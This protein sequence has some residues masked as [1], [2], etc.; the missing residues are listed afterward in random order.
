MTHSIDG[1]EDFVS[2]FGPDKWFGVVVVEFQIAID[3][4]HKVSNARIGASA[5]LFL[6]ESGEEAFYL[7]EPR[8]AGGSEVHVK[9]GMTGEPATN[10]RAKSHA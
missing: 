5:Y 6:S 8:G 4:D 2:R 7:V 10:R 1:L 9:T 3:L